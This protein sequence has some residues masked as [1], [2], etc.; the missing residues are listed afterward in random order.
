MFRQFFKKI[1]IE[2]VEKSRKLK[3]RN[4]SVKFDESLGEFSNN[5]NYA[6]SEMRS[7][8]A[9]YYYK[10]QMLFEQ[11]EL[12]AE[13]FEETDEMLSITHG[14]VKSFEKG[15]R[16]KSDEFEEF[17]NTFANYS[18]MAEETKLLMRDVFGTVKYIEDTMCHTIGIFESMLIAMDESNNILNNTINDM[19]KLNKN[20]DQINSIIKEVRDISSQT[21][22]LSLN[23]SIEAARAGEAGAGFSI[24]AQEIGKLS[25]QTDE[26]VENIE[27]TLTA[28]RDTTTDVSVHIEDNVKKV[29]DNTKAAHDTINPMKEVLEESQNAMES[30]NKFVQMQ[31]EHVE[32]QNKV[33]DVTASMLEQI[34]QFVNFTESVTDNIEDYKKRS[35]KVK[36]LITE[37][38]KSVKDIYD[39]IESYTANIKLD[40]DM[41]KKINKG[42]EIL[43]GIENPQK[44]LMAEHN[45]ANRQ[46]LKEIVNSYQFVDVICAMDKDGISRVSN[47][48]EEDGVLDFSKR[49][50][51]KES[52]KGIEY[53]SKPY[54]SIDTG[55]YT[56]TVAIPIKTSEGKIAG[57]MTADIIIN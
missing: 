22:L 51:F 6:I 23:A 54:I 8:M 57:I 37:D 36:E 33:I 16:S 21:Q 25:R 19:N 56:V 15:V 35:D 43:K 40:D 41:K 26:A 14:N 42:I 46:S 44:F 31:E 47:I 30:L 18:K 34:N 5:L 10:A 7:S 55:D 11:N 38:N 28:V 20:M 50:Y 13:Y 29:K 32:V 9:D 4:L 3:N 45:K 1:T 48:D 12:M 52:I 27:T 39:S 49:E 17:K 24:V 53:K 2:E